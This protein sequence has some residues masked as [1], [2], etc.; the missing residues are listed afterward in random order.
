M[1]VLY[2]ANIPSPYRVDFFGELARSCDL[3]VVFE[4]QKAADRKDSWLGGENAGYTTHYLKGFSVKNETAFAPSVLRFLKKNKF[5]IIVIGGYATPTAM[6][7]ILWLKLRKIP[8]VLNA[9]GGFIKPGGG[10]KEKI[11]R[12]FIGAAA[13]WICSGE[14]TKNYFA[15]YGADPEKV[16]T[17]PFTSL[18]KADILTA[19]PTDKEKQAL[20]KELGIAEAK[21]VLAVGQFIPR[22]GF[23]VLLKAWADMPEGIGLYLLGDEPSEEYLTLVRELKLKNV[24][25]AGFRPKADVLSF[26]R[27][28]DLFVLPTREDIWGLVVN[29]A[30]ASALPVVTTKQCLA[31]LTLV[32]D[33]VGRLIAAEDVPAL[34]TAMTEILSDGKKISAM[35]TSALH[36]IKSYTI[37]NMA[38]RHIEIF[39]TI[40]GR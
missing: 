20:K 25:F 35:R 39:K 34:K 18:V 5:D 14:A 38:S 11:K 4:R 32:D 22:K 36:R 7:A 23:D 27:A 37:E 15:H 28:C 29:E 3:T 31:G 8:F 6:L 12:F 40:L 24:H 33:S 13:W 2:L 30:L 26:C 16:F 1:K 19:P 21:A 17:Y 9:D 10:F